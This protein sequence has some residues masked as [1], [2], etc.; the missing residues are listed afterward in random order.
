MAAP[1]AA[2]AGKA[3]AWIGKKLAI[4]VLSDPSVIFKYI[5]IFMC[6]ILGFALLFI[7]PIYFVVSIPSTLFTGTSNVPAENE[8]LKNNAKLVG[9]YE[10]VPIIIEN[11]INEWVEKK[12]KE[13][14]ETEFHIQEGL[15]WQTVLALDAIL[16]K[17]DFSGVTKNKIIK[18][19]RT[20]IHKDMHTY[21]YTTTKTLTD[22]D[23]EEYKV[24]KVHKVYVYTVKIKSLE[25]VMNEY[26]LDDNEKLACQNMYMFTKSYNSD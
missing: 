10:S 12:K 1:L 14:E 24:K 3:A 9:I 6:I 21:T 18:T 5:L 23:G 2:A 20:F 8:L 11:E 25:N 4:D 7:A 22:E 16:H 17:Q 26:G 19:A 15:E 13:H